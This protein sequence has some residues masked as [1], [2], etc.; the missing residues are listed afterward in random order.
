[1]PLS[2][3]LHL[4]L[5]ES[6]KRHTCSFLDSD[7]KKAHKH[8]KLEDEEPEVIAYAKTVFP[9]RNKRD[10]QIYDAASERVDAILRSVDLAALKVRRKMLRNR[11]DLSEKFCRQYTKNCAGCAM[12]DIGCGQQC[13]DKVDRL[14]TCDEDLSC[15]VKA[16]EKDMR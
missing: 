15:N 2:D 1:M 7:G 4:Q 5:R 12:R 8:P 16:L 10:Q 6:G 14:A 13:L 9:T 11:L 3:V